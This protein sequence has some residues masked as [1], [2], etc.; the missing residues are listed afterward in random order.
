MIGERL[1]VLGVVS[2]ADILVKEQGP[3]NRR[4]GFLG[5]L[6][7]EEV[8]ETVKLAARTAGEAMTAPAITVGPEAHVSN[9][10]RVMT[11]NGIKRLPVVDSHGTLDRD[12]HPSR[13]RTRVRSSRPR[14]R[15]R[16]PRGCH[17]A[18]PLDRGTER[19]RTRRAR[20]GEAFR[21]ARTPRRMPSSSSSSLPASRA[22][23]RCTRRSGGAGT[24]GRC[25]GKMRP[26]LASGEGESVEAHDRNRVSAVDTG[27]NGAT[28]VVNTTQGG[29]P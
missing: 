6:L 27:P 8:P 28:I 13:P 1:E 12:R 18:H 29:S 14:D 11:E 19:R 23:C 9:A 26:P 10:A 2:E 4:G 5:R 20:R 3:V 25:R 24:I 16:D 15:A 22:S 7:A 17:S 21:T